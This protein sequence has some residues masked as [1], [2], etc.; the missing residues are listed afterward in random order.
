M[1]D[2]LEPQPVVIP[3]TLLEAAGGSHLVA[4]RL[5]RQG[6]S[7]AEQAR[8][9]LDPACYSDTDPRELPGMEA[10]LAAIQAALA[11][12]RPILVWGDFDVDGQTS[13]T[14]LVETLQSL[15]AQ[16]SY[17]IPLRESEGHGVSPTVLQGY[18]AEQPYLILTCDTG[19]S[20][21]AA[22]ETAR[23]RGVPLVITDHHDPPENLPHAAAII[24]PKLGSPAHPFYSLS[25]AG[26]RLRA[27]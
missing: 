18:L 4:A 6:I 20:A 9:F 2:W 15:G 26:Y 5:L 21:A 25:G 14:I 13:T 8:A 19:I 23:E 12:K 1:Q 10:G 27:R 24:N 7:T 17:H 22:A 16:V 3:D 11:E